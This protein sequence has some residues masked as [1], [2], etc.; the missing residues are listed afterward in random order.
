MIEKPLYPLLVKY[1]ISEFFTNDQVVLLKSDFKISQCT[2][3]LSLSCLCKQPRYRC[4]EHRI[5]FKAGLYADSDSNMCFSYSE[6]A[7]HDSTSSFLNE[8]QRLH[9]RQHGLSFDRQLITSMFFQIF[10]LW[11]SSLVDTCDFTFI[12]PPCHFFLQ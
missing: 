11:E 1:N 3:S 2:V 10:Y 7:I 5:P 4:K 9:Y 8:I 12:T 6:I